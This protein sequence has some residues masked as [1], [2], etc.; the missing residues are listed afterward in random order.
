MVSSMR[1]ASLVLAVL[2]AGL[3][4]GCSSSSSKVH[5]IV[6][7]TAAT[8]AH[9]TAMCEAQCGQTDRCPEPDVE[10]P[11]HS[12]CVDSCVTK[13]GEPTV[14]RRN[15]IEKLESCYEELECGVSDDECTYEAVILV[16][17]DPLNDPRFQAC[18]QQHEEC[19]AGSLG[20]FSDDLCAL[21]FMLTDDAQTAF[22]DCL[23]LTCDKISDCLDGIRGV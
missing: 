14:F 19:S 16:E 3:V 12:Q 23:T 4:A 9:V 15:V 18:R 7:P 17:P 2:A 1:F 10:Y 20:S 6:D 5:G 21:Y 11:P 13:I 8:P 22:D